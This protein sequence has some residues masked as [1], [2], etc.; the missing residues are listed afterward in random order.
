MA[1]DTAQEAEN[2]ADTVPIFCVGYQESK[3]SPPPSPERVRHVQS[4]NYDMLAVPITTTQFHTRVLKLISDTLAEGDSRSANGNFSFQSSQ[5]LVAPK[6]PSLS[7][8]DSDLVPNETISQ[9]LALTSSW[10]DVCS[11]DPIIASVSRQVLA[12]EVSYAAFCGVTYVVVQGPVDESVCSSDGGL[13]QFARA[14]Q[15]AL[16]VGPYI[17]IVVRLPMVNDNLNNAGE[18]GDLGRF[19]RAEYLKSHTAPAKLKDDLESWSAWN[20]IRTVCKYHV[21][22]SVG[23][24]LPKLI[25]SISIQS[26]WYCEPIRLL[27]LSA[28][29]FISNAKGFPVLSKAYQTLIFRYMRLRVPPWFVLYGVDPVP[30]S[31][32]TGALTSDIDPLH[33]DPGP[34]MTD[35]KQF[36]TLAEASTQPAQPQNTDP[37]PH[38]AYLR[39]LQAKQTPLD[40]IARFSTGYQD[41]LQAPLQPLTV[42]LESITYEVFEKDPIKYAWYGRAIARALHDW[43]EDEK[44]TSGPDGRVVVAVVGAGRGP[45]VTKALQ[46]A[47]DVGVEIDCWALEKNPNAFVLLQRMNAGVWDNQ[48]QLVKGDMRTWKGPFYSSSP[49]AET[50]SAVAP[51]TNYKIDILI[52]ELLGSFADNE[53]SPECL[54]GIQH[55]LNPARGMSIPRSYTAHFTPISTPRLHADVKAQSITNPHAPET[56]F[57]VMLDAFDYLSTITT[58]TT[59]ESPPHESFPTESPII[60]TA[61]SFAHP[62]PSL[63]GP[64]LSNTHNSRHHASS[65]T[66]PRRGVCHGLAGYFETVLYK[67]VELSTN[68][69]TMAE[70]SEGMISWFPIF[71]P[72]KS[73]VSVP[74][75]GELTINMWRCTDERKVWY[76]WVVEAFGPDEGHGVRKRIGGGEVQ[77]SVNDACLM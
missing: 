56:P 53:L 65:F 24:D 58:G 5:D 39:N 70:K 51:G 52:S 50:S 26:R 33:P 30:I 55:L 47:E 54:D 38:L 76:E 11:Q 66:T 25:P 42:N 49:A 19:A 73:P 46:A 68:P 15:D 7:P 28:S 64:L 10:I 75:E 23:L 4:F 63:P 8:S 13:M 40:A 72:L 6:V 57:V 48:V 45:L 31:A 37:Q 17:Q 44:P 69:A 1:Q 18:V 2:P 36:P 14:M 67:R 62:H 22:L 12:L 21:R 59:L 32:D 16:E 27:T 9:T 77:S 43:A 60:H 41:Y 29:I 61:W 20:T 3:S 74:D 35:H 34:S 71:F